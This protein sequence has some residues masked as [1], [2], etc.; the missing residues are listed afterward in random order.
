MIREVNAC[1]DL[2]L[3]NDNLIYRC[4]GKNVQVV[5]LID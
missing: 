5:R 2:I 4:V 1:G 3:I